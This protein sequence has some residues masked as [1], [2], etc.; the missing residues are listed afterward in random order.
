MQQP[1]RIVIRALVALVATLLLALVLS[2]QNPKF[3]PPESAQNPNRQF[4]AASGIALTT[5]TNT[6]IANLAMLGKVW[7][8]LADA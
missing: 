7:G 2:W 3:R 8:F 6:Q 5:L 1:L 4:D